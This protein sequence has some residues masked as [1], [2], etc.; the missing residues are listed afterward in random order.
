MFS[1]KAAMPFMIL[2][3]GHFL[4]PN[5]VCIGFA[6]DSQ[7]ILRES[8]I[9]IRFNRVWRGYVRASDH[10]IRPL[11]A[12]LWP[13]VLRPLKLI[14]GINTI[15]HRRLNEEPVLA[16]LCGDHRDL[17]HQHCKPSHIRDMR[18]LTAN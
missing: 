8:L 4:T 17:A 15:V 18:H 5:S 13:E 7:Q 9:R 1:L 3:A 10:L 11:V 6:G 2:L 12:W 16:L 14:V